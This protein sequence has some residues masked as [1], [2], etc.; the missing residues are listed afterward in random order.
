MGTNSHENVI[1]SKNL[2]AEHVMP[3]LKH[4]NET[5]PVATA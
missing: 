1:K 2:F 4:I 5:T 3:K